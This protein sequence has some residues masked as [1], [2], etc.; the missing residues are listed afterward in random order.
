MNCKYCGK[1]MGK[2]NLSYHLKSIHNQKYEDYIKNNL[3]EFKCL[4]WKLCSECGTCCKSTSDKCGKCYTKTHQIKENQYIHCKY[5]NKDIKSKGIANH[6]KFCH[7]IEFSNYVRENLE[8][9]RKFGWA[10]CVICKN[11]CRSY[12]QSYKQPTCSTECLKELRKTWVAEKSRMFGT[13]MSDESKRKNAMA[14]IG[15]IMPSMTGTLNPACRPEVR[16]QIS[17]TRIERGVAKGEF[18][19]MYGK[20]HTAEAIKK[21]MSHRPMNKLERLVA[22]E[23]DKA[24]ISYYFQYFITDNGICK[25]YD[26][27]IKGKPII[28]EVD[29]DFW[30]GNPNTKNH[31]IHVNETIENDKLKTEMAMKRG[32][33]V[34][35]LWES[36]IKKDPSIVLKYI[37]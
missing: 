25:S 36:D 12:S 37:A 27:K 24:N 8:N 5:C 6:L 2:S 11:I 22:D 23:F 14:H 35:R 33:Q 19:P 26:F 16:A 28:I 34:I 17:K 18:N 3:N 21:I 15:K 9:F 32:F 31:H 4:G 30:H 29:G 13:T 7:N 10:E 20:T 1:E